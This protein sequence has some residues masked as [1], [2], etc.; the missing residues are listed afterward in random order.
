MNMHTRIVPGLLAGLLL[1]IAAGAAE[2]LKV[3]VVDL[4]RIMKAYGET[5]AAETVLQKQVDEFELEKQEMEQKFEVLKKE[6]EAA[7][8]EAEESKHLSEA[9]REKKLEV[10]K[11]KLLAVKK[12]EDEL[13]QT[14]GDRRKD[15][16]ERSARM[17]RRIVGKLKERIAA[18]AKEK[19]YTLILDAAAVGTA[20]GDMVVFFDEKIDITGEILKLTAELPAEGKANEPDS[21]TTGG[22][23]AGKR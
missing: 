11:E 10:A 4:E 9:A 1:S 8:T 19:G 12:Y 13:R 20:G 23:P 16:T 2:P 3:A 18:Y 5:K 22:K 17:S 6:F 15:L 21:G 14:L 7:R